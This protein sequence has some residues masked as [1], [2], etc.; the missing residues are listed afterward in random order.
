MALGSAAAAGSEAG[1]E[2]LRSAADA[3]AAAAAQRRKALQDQAL[4]TASFGT[5][6][7]RRRVSD[8]PRQGLLCAAAV[9]S[10]AATVRY[11]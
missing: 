11:L 6:A 7:Q 5:K 2:M 3:A 4:L 10:G 8:W 1:R 9:R